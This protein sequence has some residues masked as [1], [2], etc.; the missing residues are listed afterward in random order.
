MHEV[1]IERRIRKK[2]ASEREEGEGWNTTCELF[3][4][5]IWLSGVHRYEQ[6]ALF[7]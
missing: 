6:K 1:H 2:A 7:Q 3:F 4:D 5:N